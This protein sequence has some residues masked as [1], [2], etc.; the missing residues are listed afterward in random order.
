M[1]AS[2]AGELSKEEASERAE[3]LRDKIEYHNY[4][5][6]VLNDPEISDAEYDELK[7]ELE[8]IEEKCPDL[9]TPDSPTQRVGAEPQDELGTVEHES[10]ML[11]LQSIQEEEEF[12]HFYR[13]CCDKL[14]KERISLVA[15]PK[16]D[17]LSVELVY[18]QGSFDHGSTRGDGRTGEDVTENLKTIHEV[19]L[20]L[21]TTDDASLP[22]HLI[23]RG[24]VYI[25][26]R[27][28]QQF[29]QQREEAGEKTF[30]NP[31]NAAAGSLRQ[32]DPQITARRPLRIFFWEIAPTSSSRPDSQWQCLELMRDLGLKTNPRSERFQ[33]VNKA[34]EWYR[35]MQE[36]REDL[37]YEIDGC[38]FK[39]NVLADHETLGTRAA[40]PRWAIAWKFP[41]RRRN[42][43]IEDIRPQVGRTGAITPVAILRPVRIG[44]VEVSRVS[45]HNQDEIDR[46]D[47]R[48]GDTVL[49]ERAGDVI[50]HVVEVIEDKRSGNEEKYQLPDKCPV[51]GAPAGRPA[52]EAVKRCTNASCPAQRKARIQ[53]FGSKP[54]LDIEGLGEQTVDQLV[55]N[56]MVESVADLFALTV[57]D[58][59]KLNHMAEKS[60]RNLI[61]AVD[62]ARENVTLPRLLY[63]LGLPH[64]GRATAGDIAREFGSLDALLDAGKE[65]LQQME[66]VGKTVGSAVAQWFENP[67]NRELLDRLKEL[68]IWPSEEPTGDRLEGLTFVLT[69]S[70]D[71]MTREEAMEAIRRQGGRAT[72]GVS[73]ETDYLVVGS[74]P[75]DTKLEAAQEYGTERIGENRFLELLGRE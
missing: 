55:E 44:G 36:E 6:Y 70:L 65:R 9:V 15:E 67:R 54:A 7:R 38:V 11:S 22:Q 48:I 57:E 27:E 61:D 3:E 21:Q 8:D 30:A 62:R 26:K 40:S 75:G 24:E 50:P 59:K 10:P 43:R 5:Y 23:V 49:V 60:A 34:V 31:R 68:G 4:R 74:E 17:G 19:P 64:V 53:H 1:T 47:I 42:T 16:Y 18:E 29:N 69:G 14:G 33:S 56:E 2:K 52:G 37:A 28:F 51:C 39:V 45:L 46:K 35:S 12:R 73:G 32:L 66:G 63:G 20:R 13:T 41:S 71:S 72:G 58:V 25:E